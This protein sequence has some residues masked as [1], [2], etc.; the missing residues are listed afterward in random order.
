VYPQSEWTLHRQRETDDSAKGKQALRKRRKFYPRTDESEM[1]SGKI[2]IP[3]K[4]RQIH[5]LDK[6]VV[7]VGML[8]TFE[9][10]TPANW[11]KEQ[12]E[13]DAMPEE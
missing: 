4:L 9:I 8:E 10:W 2:L 11:E 13:L 12:A 1:K 3:A 6:E 7:L 5:G